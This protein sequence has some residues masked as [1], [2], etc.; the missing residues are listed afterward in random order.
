ML[1]YLLSAGSLIAAKCMNI[2]HITGGRAEEPQVLPTING[3]EGLFVDPDVLVSDC[4]GVKR[5]GR[6]RRPPGDMRLL[7]DR[8]TPGKSTK[9]NWSDCLSSGH[10]DQTG[11]D[12]A[13]GGGN[14]PKTHKYL[15]DDKQRPLSKMDF[16]P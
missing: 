16:K 2:N 9:W 15:H 12:K 13:G 14:S 8:E 4:R 3:G 1:D 6:H 11:K 5:S 10:W 7:G